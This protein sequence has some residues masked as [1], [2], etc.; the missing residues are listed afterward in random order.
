M[1]KILILFICV[2]AFVSC[3]KES[4]ALNE[5]LKNERII[6]QTSIDSLKKVK[7]NIITFNDSLNK[8]NHYIM[9]N[10]ESRERNDKLISERKKIEFDINYNT[11]IRNELARQNDVLKKQIE[12]N[13]FAID[14]S[15]YIYVI[16][17]RVHQTTYTL[18]ISEHIKNKMNDIIFDI[19]VDKAYYDKCLVG[20]KITDPGLKLGS[21]LRDGDFSKL[22]ITITGKKTLKR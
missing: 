3:D 15:K 11:N 17:V 9:T 7:A 1:K 8:I 14:V 20:Q 4:A 22:K 5:I 12:K 21:L 2:F 10:Q 16:T 13:Q 19:P 6:L 18:S